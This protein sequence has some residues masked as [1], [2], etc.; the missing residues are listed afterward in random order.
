MRRV[1]AVT[2]PYCD[3]LANFTVRAQIL[4]YSEW[5]FNR[6]RTG[7]ASI[8]GLTCDACSGPVVGAMLPGAI[9]SLLWHEPKAV[10]SANFPDVP[11]NI[12]SDAT[13]AFRCSSVGAWRAT[14]AIARRAVQAAAIQQGASDKKLSHQIN[15]LDEGRKI[16]PQMRE[17]AHEIRLAEMTERTRTRT[18][19]K[20]SG[21]PGG[22]RVGL[23][24]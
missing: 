21:R 16:T 4:N 14:V 12:A 7:N 10:V 8:F 5:R 9:G 15:W 2:C 20:K 23:S 6:A 17:L 3:A 18:V 19:C 1:P 24:S 13:E 11:P 22:S